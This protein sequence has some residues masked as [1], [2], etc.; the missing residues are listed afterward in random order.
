MTT[1]SILTLGCRLNQADSALIADELRRCG[2]EVVRWGEAADV[3][4]VNS[5]AVT[6]A[7]AQKTRQALRAARRRA[8]S[9]FLVLA[10]CSANLDP[11]GCAHQLDVDLVLPNPVK[12]RI[13]DYLPAESVRPA[14]PRVV[15]VDLADY[16][17]PVFTERGRGY[18]PLRTRANLKIQEGCDFGCSYCIVPKARGR[19]RSRQADDVLREARELVAAGYREIVV[20]GVNIAAYRDGDTDL[21]GLLEDLLALR[22]DF[23]L[24]LSSTEP[25]PVLARI[26]DIMASEPR[27]CPFL[28]LPLQH[29]DDDVLR[30]MRRR[31]R[32]SEFERLVG[33][34]VERIPGLGIGSDVIVGF[35]GETE[36]A[37][38]QSVRVIDSL[39]FSFLHVFTFSPRPGTLAAS[40]P[41][42]VP[43]PVAADRSRRLRK[44][45]EAKERAFG[46]ANIGRQLR[47]L[48]EVRG[49]SGQFEGWS[50]NYLRVAIPCP[51]PG[52]STNEWV[53]V[54]VSAVVKGR[55]VEGQPL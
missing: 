26:V 9:A 15:D 2:Y 22:G 48:T 6:T 18:Y 40:F 45:A 17:E 44:M 38:E 21:A 54:R 50:E 27:L 51:P 5:C 25:G 39:P 43:G 47:V 10:G 55:V 53:N 41:D 12:T 24:R 35:P 34:A 19:A 16:S 23:R 14:R 13:S 49:E 7:A 11:E 37:F 42:R 31:Y 28:H 8:P 52:L 20:T 3:L 46:E 30:A 32:V 1:A 29:G 33:L 36:A 4:V